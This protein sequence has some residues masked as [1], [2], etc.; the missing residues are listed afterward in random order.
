MS[1]DTPIDP[2]DSLDEPTA[3][4]LAALGEL[5]GNKAVWDELPA[6]LEDSVVAAITSEQQLTVA[7]PGRQR[8]RWLAVAAVAL[9]AFGLGALVTQ[10]G[11]GDPDGPAVTEF[12]LSPTDLAGGATGT[13]ELAELSNGL[14]IILAV[15]S[16]P[17]APEGQFY[18]AWMRTPDSG[19]SA[20][21]FH[22]RGETGEIELWAGVLSDGYP[23][24]SITLENEDGDTS[25]SGRVVM[26][27]DLT[28]P[29]SG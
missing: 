26:K 6:G 29:L 27:A 16:L 28:E 19:V 8:P 18:E 22:M 11:S 17:P 20:G 7:A 3:D 5:L 23:I 9:V 4:E 25:S 1:D 10:L 24:F 21:T 2:I 12:A 13:V 15:D 14:R